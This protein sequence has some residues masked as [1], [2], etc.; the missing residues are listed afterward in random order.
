MKVAL[1][2][3]QQ[4]ICPALWSS[5]CKCPAVADTRVIQSGLGSLLRLL[6]Y[7]PDLIVCGDFGPAAL[8]ASIYRSF[9]PR[10]RL[11][12]C[13]AG[14]PWRV[15]TRERTILD[16]T[17]A[18]LATGQ[19]AAHAIEQLAAPIGRVFTVP[20]PFG[21]EPFLGCEPARQAPAAHRLVH[22]GDLSPQ[23]GAADLLTCVAACAEQQPAR[24]IEIWWAGEGDLAGV[25][26]AQPL[27]RN[28]S[29]RFLGRL[30]T[31]G[32]ASAFGQC[33]LLVV[34]SCT[35]DGSSTL[36]GQPLIACGMAAG[37]PVLGSQR[38]RGVRQLVREGVTGWLFDPVRPAEMV[39]AFN[40]ALNTP[41]GQ[42]DAMRGSARALVRPLGAEEFTD[43]LSRII[44]A[45]MPEP[46]RTPP[47][48]RVVRAA[49]RHGTVTGDA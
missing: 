23:S 28:M 19:A 15:G 29:Q 40:H 21:V 48:R 6:S 17:D 41:V 31:A 43:Q 33:G 4:D 18:V 1:L 24:P 49:P 30:A 26:A 36:D 9:S 11:L 35:D 37:L 12:L 46:V 10:S 34:P 16:W 45:T 42:L 47:A 25:L 3:T 38:S 32:L 14:A 20:T 8:Q 44:A 39:R 2:T 13:A 7:G 27:P 5:L 22:A